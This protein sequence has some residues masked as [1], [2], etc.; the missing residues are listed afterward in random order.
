MHKPTTLQTLSN[1]WKCLLAVTEQVSVVHYRIQLKPEASLKVVHVDQLWLHPCHK[2][3]T[4]W[5]RDELAH[6][7][8]V[9]NVVDRGT[10]PNHIEKVTV[11]VNIAH[12]NADTEPIITRSTKNTL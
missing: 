12:Q 9:N 1:G 7:K 5:V 4:I 10:S 3:R 6:L 2:D 8:D 11:G